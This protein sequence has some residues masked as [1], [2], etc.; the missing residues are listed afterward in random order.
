MNI[1][2]PIAFDVIHCVSQLFDYYLYAVYTFFG[3]NDMVWPFNPSLCRITWMCSLIRNFFSSYVQTNCFYGGFFVSLFQWYV[4]ES[5]TAVDRFLMGVL[6]IIITA[7]IIRANWA[8]CD[9][10]G[11]FCS[12][13]SVSKSV[14]GKIFPLSV[15][16][17]CFWGIYP[18]CL[19]SERCYCS[20]RLV[21]WCPAHKYDNSI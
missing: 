7:I 5:V 17:L 3:R 13:V 4:Y 11:I 2:K 14:K 6:E 10:V 1:L 18:L 15:I 16:V 12:S 21:S 8:S 20:K 9:L 19:S